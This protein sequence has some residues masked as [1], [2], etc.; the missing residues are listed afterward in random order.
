ADSASLVPGEYV[1]KTTAA[2]GGH[3]ATL[4]VYYLPVR[5]VGGTA[6]PPAT[7][8]T[9]DDMR[10]YCAWIDRM[11]HP[12]RRAQ[13]VR[14]RARA[15]TWYDLLIQRH[16][17][18]SGYGI[19]TIGYPIGGIGPYRTGA[20]NTWLQQQLDANT[21][22]ITDDLRECLAKKALGFALEYQLGSTQDTA[23]QALADRFHAE[24]DQLA[25]MTTPGLDLDNDGWPDLIVDLSAADTLWA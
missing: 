13:F 16:F 4:G 24:A 23:Y 2:R 11:E 15:R 8:G 1:L 19:S 5:Q 20:T 14:E 10:I 22:M 7:Y 6:T 25:V 17:R 9:L 12:S 18:A 21:L 3:T